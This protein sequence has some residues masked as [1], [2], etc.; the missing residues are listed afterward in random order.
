MGIG[1]NAVGRSRSGHQA[2]RT[3][4]TW[5]TSRNANAR[6]GKTTSHSKSGDA[7]ATRYGRCGGC[8]TRRL[9]PCLANC[10]SLA[11]WPR[12]VRHLAAYCRTQSVSRPVAPPTRDHW[13]YNARNGRSVPER[14]SRTDRN[15]TWRRCSQRDLQPAGAAAR[16]NF[17]GSLSRFVGRGGCLSFGY[18]RRCP[19]IPIGTRTT[20]FTRQTCRAGG[21]DRCVNY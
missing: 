19:G 9:C 12:Q 13:R 17:A 3:R 16:G 4:W 20:H 10:R 14:G 21:G 7:N 11:A 1:R 8:R 15:R 2:D 6:G 18:Q 5:R